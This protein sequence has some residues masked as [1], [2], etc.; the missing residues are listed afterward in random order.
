MRLAAVAKLEGS[1]VELAEERG[2]A[3]DPVLHRLVGVEQ[4]RQHEVGGMSGGR[5]HTAPFARLIHWALV[6]ALHAIP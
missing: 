6:S 5:Q 2:A 3:L 1:V 4:N